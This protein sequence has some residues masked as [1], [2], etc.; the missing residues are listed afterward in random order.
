MKK[1][2]L[3]LGLILVILLSITAVAA[4]N[5]AYAPRL[6]FSGTTAI[7]TA[8]VTAPNEEIDV[9]LTLWRGDEVVYY[10]NGHGTDV[11]AIEGRIRV[12]AGAEYTL[13]LT[14]FV[15]DEDIGE[16]SVNGTC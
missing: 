16:I 5:Y 14:G 8:T 11:V 3:S 12:A 13:T 2:L 6:R 1:R 7:C 10:W 15:G 4:E 9:R